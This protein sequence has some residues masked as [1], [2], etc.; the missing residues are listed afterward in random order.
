MEKNRFRIIEVTNNWPAEVF[1]QRHISALEEQG[2]CL[3][4]IARHS[5]EKYTQSASVDI[6]HRNVNLMPNFNR[7][8]AFK[9]ILK[10]RYLIR[11]KKVL[12]ITEKSLGEKVLFSYFESLQPDLIHFHDSSL[13]ILMSWIPHL[14]GT[15]YSFSL[16]GSDIQ[17]LPLLSG[18]YKEKLRDVILNAS[19]VHS[20]CDVLWNEAKVAYELPENSIFH[21]TIYTTV[22]IFSNGKHTSKTKKCQTSNFISIGRLHWRKAYISLLIAFRIFINNGNNA[23]LTIVGEGQGREELIYWINEL[24]LNTSVQLLGKMPYDEFQSLIENADGY[25]QSSIAEGFSNATAEAMALGVPVFATAVGGTNEIIRDG[26][27]GFLL[28]AHNPQ[29]W[30]EKF[31]LVENQVLMEKIG[32]NAMQTAMTIFSSERHGVEFIEFYEHMLNG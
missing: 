8:S 24:N 22:P 17:V 28:D 19:G 29:I 9:K 14:S 18:E 12:N 1:I 13:A 5:D 23:N 7:L 32:A 15:P 10:L 11:Y 21:K 31:K 4:V 2:I 16:R 20:V 27:N 6:S 25:I 3:K 26:E 30:Y